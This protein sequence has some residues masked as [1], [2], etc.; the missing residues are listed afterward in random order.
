MAWYGLDSIFSVC[1]VYQIATPVRA[2]WVRLRRAA[3][4]LPAR[5]SVHICITHIVHGPS[6]VIDKRTRLLMLCRCAAQLCV[7]GQ[8]QRR[9]TRKG[10]RA[11]VSQSSALS[12][13]CHLRRPGPEQQAVALHHDYLDPLCSVSCGIS[14]CRRHRRRQVHGTRCSSPNARC[15]GSCSGSDCWTRGAAFHREQGTK[16]A[17]A[18]ARRACCTRSRCYPF[19]R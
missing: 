19:A 7:H 2:I 16:T 11:S 13:I 3:A 14:S 15:H 5:H 8:R 17:H 1:S 6:D 9:E 4:L 12:L 18:R 10:T